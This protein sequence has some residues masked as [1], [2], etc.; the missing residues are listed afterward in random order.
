MKF[1]HFFHRYFLTFPAPSRSTWPLWTRWGLLAAWQEDSPPTLSAAPSAGLCWYIYHLCLLWIIIM[2]CFTGWG[3]VAT[4]PTDWS[5]I[6]GQGQE[7]CNHWQEVLSLW[8]KSIN[9][10]NTSI[11][12]HPKS[13]FEKWTFCTSNNIHYSTSSITISCQWPSWRNYFSPL[14]P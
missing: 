13:H 11:Q 14:F 3:K 6:S 1:N 12:W 8:P 9:H 10:W 4:G 7:G 5:M 2:F